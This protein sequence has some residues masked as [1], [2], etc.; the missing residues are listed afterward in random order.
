MKIMSCLLVVDGIAIHLDDADYGVRLFDLIHR[1]IESL[2]PGDH[3]VCEFAERSDD[4]DDTPTWSCLL[5]A[6]STLALRIEA[7]G[8]SDGMAQTR[9]RDI[10]I[11]SLHLMS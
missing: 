8:G 10:V 6:D 5:H 4:D 7:D 11:D 9:R 2:A 3:V 1:R